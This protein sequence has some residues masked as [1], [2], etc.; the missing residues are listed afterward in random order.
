MNTRSL[1]LFLLTLAG[2][3]L[4]AGLFAQ[5]P[6]APKI[7]FPAAS[8]ASTLKQRVGVT[9]IEI[10]YNRPSMKG[11][12]IFGGLVP[13]GQIW[14]T[15]ADAATRITLSTAAT[16][17][18]TAVSAGTYELFTI[19]GETEWTVILQG[20]KEKAQ[21]GSYA[22]NQENDTAR[23]TAT[24]VKSP[25]AYETFGIGIGSLSQTGATMTLAWENTRVPVKIEVD[26][27]GTLVPQIEAVMASDAEKKPYF[28]SAMFYYEN[29]LDIEKAAEWI[30][31]AAEAQPNAFW[32]TYRQGLI[33][34]KKGDKA[35][36]LAAAEKSKEVAATQTGELKD[37]YLRLNDALIKS[38][39]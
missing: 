4:T 34:A 9:D 13:Y 32:L 36:A 35:G 7:D 24:P 37:E 20:V 3:A 11:R 38:L 18:G 10:N 5:A 29:G 21:W 23:F 12:K 1:R 6:A 30:A 28:A 19:P 22:Y 17:N 8:P 2:S 25:K 27:V 16:L 31:K 15:G 26:T 14:R 33:L 39:N